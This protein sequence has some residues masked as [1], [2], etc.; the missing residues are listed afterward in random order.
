MIRAA[1]KLIAVFLLAAGLVVL[2]RYRET[3]E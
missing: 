3:L 2:N 1:E